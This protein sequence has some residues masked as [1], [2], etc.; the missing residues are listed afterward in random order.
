MDEG[1]SLL[2]M[3]VHKIKLVVVSEQGL[4]L[5]MNLVLIPGELGQSH[6]AQ[7]GN[8]EDYDET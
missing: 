3:G 5:T 4:T 1:H 6:L 2:E 7:E 8:G